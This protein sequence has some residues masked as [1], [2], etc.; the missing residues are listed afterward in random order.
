MKKLFLSCI[1]AGLSC[2]ASAQKVY[3][4]YLQ[5]DDLAP[6]YV[7][8]GDK[9]YSSS[10]AG[11]L[12][13]PNLVD[14][15]YKIGLGFAKSTQPETRFAV[16]IRQNDKGYLVKNFAEGMSL[17]DMQD[18]SLVKCMS[19]TP[20]NTVYETKSD[21]FSSVLSKAANDPSLLKVAVGKKEEP[22][23]Q[24][25]KEE[26]VIARQEVPKSEPVPVVDT[27]YVVQSTTHSLTT[28]TPPDSI[29]VESGT[30]A[31]VVVEEIKSSDAGK[32]PVAANSGEPSVYKPSTI[33]R[34]SESSTT[35]GFGVVFLDKMDGRT[36]TIRILIPPSRVKLAMEP[37]VA[38]LS[39]IEKKAENSVPVEEASGTSVVITPSVPDSSKRLVD[40][41]ESTPIPQSA[42]VTSCRQSASEKDFLKLRKN[43]AS[44]NT[45]EAM[46]D[47]AKKAFRSKCFSVEQLR[48]L[49]TLFLTSA[50]KYQFFDAA[51]NHVSDRQNFSSLQGEIKDEYYL[52]R[53]KALAGE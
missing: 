36:D 7:R 11:Y 26:V 28:N 47:E 2:V 27:N 44:E 16:S 12:I 32:E 48:Y 8:M 40:R 35:E 14:S 15:T 22:V 21:K 13:L 49:S 9:I 50:A 5:T 25:Q 4:L 10:T 51:F 17:F 1:V 20:S 30:T 45:D 42:N 43:M 23:K 38:N 19:A 53:F 41:D 52:K 39:E 31:T 18:L 3:F 37:P 24:E 29:K 6:F 34:R 33:I 46:I